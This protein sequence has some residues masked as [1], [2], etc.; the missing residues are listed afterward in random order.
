MFFMQS[1][2]FVRVELTITLEWFF[3]G[4]ITDPRSCQNSLLFLAR[5]YYH[6]DI[7]H[8]VRISCCSKQ[9][10]FSWSQLLQWL[11]YYSFTGK[12]FPEIFVTKMGVY[13]VKKANDWQMAPLGRGAASAQFRLVAA[14]CCRPRLLILIRNLDDF[15]PNSRSKHLADNSSILSESCSKSI[16]KFSLISEFWTPAGPTLEVE[17]HV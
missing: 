14:K 5:A 1:R 11:W 6:F 2:F 9:N 10:I 7:T 16:G 17:E 15:S 12:T 13:I 4:K 3:S 8:L